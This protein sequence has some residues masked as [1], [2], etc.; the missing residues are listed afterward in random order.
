MGT[1]DSSGGWPFVEILLMHLSAKIGPFY[2][3]FATSDYLD[4]W[5][6]GTHPWSLMQQPYIHPISPLITPTVA[7]ILDI[8]PNIHDRLNLK[9]DS[10]S[11]SSISYIPSFGLELSD[12]YKFMIP[13][14]IYFSTFL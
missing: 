11:A 6:E 8:S 4:R 3:L 5:W 7:K 2:P 1:L 13:L 14:E 9:T 10:D 12:F